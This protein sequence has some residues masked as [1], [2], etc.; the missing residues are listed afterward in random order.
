MSKQKAVAKQKPVGFFKSK[1][2]DKAH[3]VFPKTKSVI[4]KKLDKTEFAGGKIAELK[5]TC[6]GEDGKSIK[7]DCPIRW[8][9]EKTEPLVTTEQRDVKTGLQVWTKYEGGASTKVFRDENGDAVAPEN[10]ILV[11]VEADGSRQEIEPFTQSKEM[12]AKPIDRDVMDEF[13]PSSYV[14]IWS[15]TTDG[16]RQLRQL[17]WSLLNE[18]KVAG[19]KQFVKAKGTKTYVGF[20]YPVMGPNNTFALEMMVSENRRQ[21]HIWMPEDNNVEIVDSKAEAKKNKNVA[22]VP[23]LF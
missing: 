6:T 20:I 3:P 12:D 9:T 5:M 10:V 13:L 21:R 1:G 2:D 8:E 17:A 18:G 4:I 22:K 19:V 14:E 15:D 16:Q 23:D 11:Q 7:I